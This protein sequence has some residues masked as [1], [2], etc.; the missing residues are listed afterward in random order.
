[1]NHKYNSEKKK[2]TVH[3][4][5]LILLMGVNVKVKKKAVSLWSM[6]NMQTCSKVMTFLLCNQRVFCDYTF[7]P[8]SDSHT[9][10]HSM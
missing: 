3:I 5:Q 4:L 1:M 6:V 9:C 2:G 10:I 7:M 8:V